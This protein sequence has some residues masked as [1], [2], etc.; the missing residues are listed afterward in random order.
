MRP[1]GA[2]APFAGG[3]GLVSHA[4]EGAGTGAGKARNGTVGRP[5]GALDGL[6]LT[7][8]RSRAYRDEVELS[9]AAA[10]CLS[11]GTGHPG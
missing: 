7:G 5:A 2:A 1:Q 10:A 4:V 8:W 3:N 11:K 6:G 9:M